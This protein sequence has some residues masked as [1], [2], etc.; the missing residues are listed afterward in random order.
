M[1][2]LADMS[3]LMQQAVA[4]AGH[5]GASV[6]KTTNKAKKGANQGG[7]PDQPQSPEPAPKRPKTVQP[8]PTTS[9]PVGAEETTMSVEDFQAVV[10][11][12]VATWSP[13]EPITEDD[14]VG[15]SPMCV[16]AKLLPPPPP[17]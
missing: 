3:V 4:E 1:L 11:P 5:N 14:L 17:L 13:V 6:K 15:A 16:F 9:P 7:D 2:S 8:I 10:T 12:H